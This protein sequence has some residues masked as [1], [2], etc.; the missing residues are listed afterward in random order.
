MREL[1]QTYKPLVGVL[2]LCQVLGL[3]RATW[4]RKQTEAGQPPSPAGRAPKAT[5]PPWP[6]GSIEIPQRI[7]AKGDRSQPRRLPR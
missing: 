6:P 7:K 1:V 3:S 4:Y 2:V 5:C